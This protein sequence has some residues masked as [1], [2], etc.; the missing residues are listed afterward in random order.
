MRVSRIFNSG[1]TDT[2]S[3]V[4]SARVVALAGN[5]NSGKTSV[6]NAITGS[7][8]K[9][10]NYA[11]VTIEKKEGC[12][13]SKEG[14]KINVLDLPGLYSLTSGAPEERLA[15]AVLLGNQE[16][17]PRPDLAV[18]VV[19]ATNLERN[20]YLALQ[21]KETGIPIIIALNMIDLA[22]KHGF[23]INTK[24]M[25]KKLEVPVLDISAKTGEGIEELKK[26]I[27]AEEITQCKAR[28][29]K[30]CNETEHVLEQARDLLTE[31]K[32]A[33]KQ[34]ADWIARRALFAGENIRPGD[35]LHL[36]EEF[37]A[38][39]TKLPKDK[40]DLL[41]DEIIF[42][43]RR[44]RLVYAETVQH[45]ES[46]D[47]SKSELA[48]KILLHKIAGPL[49]FAVIM[50][51]MFQGVYTWS[52]V[53]M[54]WVEGLIENLGQFVSLNMAEGELK[55]LILDGIIAGV[56]NIIIFLPQIIILF[57][58]ISI[59]EDT[60]YMARAAFL[61][62]R[63]MSKAGLNGHSFIPLLSSFACAV[64]GI[65]ATR[66]IRSEKDRLVTIMVAPLM[67]CSA[68]L[69]VYTL[70][71][72]AFFPKETLFGFIDIRG[73]VMT[74]LYLGGIVSALFVAWVLKKLLVKGPRSPLIL[75]MPSYKF[76]RI[77]NVGI[78]IWNSVFSFM[79]RAGT[80]ILLLTIILW[81][82]VSHPAGVE[83]EKEL[84]AKGMSSAEIRMEKTK[85]SYLGTIGQTIEPVIAPLGYDWKI[86][87]GLISAFAAR[88]VIVGTM[89]IIY[90]AGSEEKVEELGTALKSDKYADGTLVWT[91][92]V[93]V[94]LLEFFIFACMCSS[95]LVTIYKET[96]TLKWPTF[97]FLYTLGLAYL[98]SFIVYQGGK[99]LGFA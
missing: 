83:M 51:V 29:W 3:P 67:T 27:T 5:P 52:E 24:L 19:D 35:A 49:I 60:G 89:A 11:G 74:A 25:E 65:M 50:G 62:D 64:P 94:S 31:N 84:A 72:G 17:A 32:L 41:D 75:E 40:E 68:R 57:F 77:K 53:P 9:T 21:V 56:G 23:S 71:I 43:Y 79:K 73:I 98:A 81:F 1:A 13:Y 7:R 46:G 90:S 76:P 78:T 36:R 58:F 48:D 97:V 66:T 88:E 22:R 59:L 91:P 69:P 16:D 33:N 44:I 10:G 80:I 37:T 82:L 45:S 8:Q 34:N 15:Q 12:C 54:Q 39:A 92:L 47:S 86:G 61:Q 4:E 38:L 70:L 96:N 95:T 63:I 20:L 30:M 93:A 18:V 14:R 85:H 26:L 99:L 87:V 55:N 6:F 42:R 28:L 2:I